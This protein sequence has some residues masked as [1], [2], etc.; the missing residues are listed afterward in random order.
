VEI[1]T[2]SGKIKARKRLINETGK[3]VFKA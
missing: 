2:L 1:P 3:R